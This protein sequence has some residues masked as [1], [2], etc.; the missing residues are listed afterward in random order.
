MTDGAPPEHFQR[1]REK[2]D[3][4]EGMEFAEGGKK[5]DAPLPR[6]MRSKGSRDCGLRDCAED[7][8]RRSSE[9]KR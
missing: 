1:I 3:Y 5:T 4:G 2:N 8:F 7:A 6:K 9:Q